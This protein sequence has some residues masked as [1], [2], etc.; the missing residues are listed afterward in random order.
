MTGKMS[1]AGSQ[2]EVL[3]QTWMTKRSQLK[4]RIS[5]TNYKERWFCLTRSSL[6]YY[7]GD[8]EVKRKEKGR[9]MVRDIQV[10]EQVSPRLPILKFYCKC[11]PM[12]RM[13]CPEKSI[14]NCL[15]G[16]S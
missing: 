2:D 7:D 12:S 8:D 15:A 11:D 14:S 4:S 5:W 13:A 1:M 10:V 6:V 3:K 16:D 9:I